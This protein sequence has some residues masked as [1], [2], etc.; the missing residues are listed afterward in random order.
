MFTSKEW[1][2]LKQLEERNHRLFL[3][4]SADPAKDQHTSQFDPLIKPMTV[5]E[6]KNRS[7][8]R[9]KMTRNA[10]ELAYAFQCRMLPEKPLVQ[11]GVHDLETF[12]WLFKGLCWLGSL[13][14][15]GDLKEVVE[16]KYVKYNAVSDFGSSGDLVS[17]EAKKLRERF[18]AKNPE[19]YDEME[20]TMDAERGLDQVKNL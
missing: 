8:I 10:R 9:R 16:T 17:K 19:M 15:I 1:N 5:E 18:R 4:W 2:Y 20:K 6:R 14:R 7:S 13:E 12:V 3:E 11:A